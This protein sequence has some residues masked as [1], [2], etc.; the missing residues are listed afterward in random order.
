MTIAGFVSSSPDH[1]ATL[2]E[3]ILLV[4][5]EQGLLGNELFAIDGCKMPSNAAKD[6]FIRNEFEL[7]KIANDR[8]LLLQNLHFP[9]PCG[10]SEK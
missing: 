7:R 6:K 2:F 10:S 8:F 1:I 4:C 9:H 5:H 3:Q